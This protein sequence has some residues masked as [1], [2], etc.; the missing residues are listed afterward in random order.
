MSDNE[1]DNSESV[2]EDTTSLIV[3]TDRVRERELEKAAREASNVIDR[4]SHAAWQR[5]NHPERY[6]KMERDLVLN[7]SSAKIWSLDRRIV[8]PKHR[9]T[10]GSDTRDTC[11]P[12][13][14][15]CVYPSEDIVAEVDNPLI[16]SYRPCSKRAKQA[17]K[18]VFDGIQCLENEDQLQ[19]VFRAFPVQIE[20][21]DNCP[22]GYAEMT[23]KDLAVSFCFDRE[24]ECDFWGNEMSCEDDNSEG[25]ED[26]DKLMGKLRSKSCKQGYKLMEAFL[27]R[28][29]NNRPRAIYG[30]KDTFQTVKSNLGLTRNKPKKWFQA[31]PRAQEMVGCVPNFANW[32]V[33]RRITVTDDACM[34]KIAPSQLSN[35]TRGFDPVQ[36]FLEH[37]NCCALHE[38]RSSFKS[39]SETNTFRGGAH[40]TEIVPHPDLCAHP[41]K[42]GKHVKMTIQ[43]VDQQRNQTT[44]MCLWWSA[45]INNTAWPWAVTLLVCLSNCWIGTSSEVVHLSIR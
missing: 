26:L 16:F 13:K 6:A 44:M 28:P 35:S 18:E 21:H 11:I 36:F 24:D 17:F 20:P 38:F 34:C 22:L 19:N 43:D 15:I 40:L 41:V 23:G 7:E 2:D 42:L 12:S 45:L 8:F 4:A 32:L 14:H 30:N 37:W 1:E 29:Y 25:E 5:V 27:D 31:F 10:L 33:E 9:P 3:V 39:N